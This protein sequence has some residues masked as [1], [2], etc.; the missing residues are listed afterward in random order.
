MI[1]LF[2]IVVFLLI[3]WLFSR[4]KKAINYKTILTALLF[5]FI[6]EISG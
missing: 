6:I 5:E 4:N 1:G 3:A 2:G